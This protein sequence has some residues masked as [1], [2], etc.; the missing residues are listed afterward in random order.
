MRRV[1]DTGAF[2]YV[3]APRPRARSPCATGRARKSPNC[4][5]DVE[6]DIPG[7]GRP[8]LWHY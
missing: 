7:P 2:V 8:A 6:T 4:V 3:R 1:S 5:Q